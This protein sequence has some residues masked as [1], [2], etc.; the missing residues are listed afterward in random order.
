MQ[1]TWIFRVS[2]NYTGHRCAFVTLEAGRFSHIL[3]Q[4]SVAEA[5]YA[6]DPMAKMTAV[7]TGRILQKVSMHAM[8]QMFP[9]STL[10]QAPAG[11]CIN[12]QRRGRHQSEVDF[13]CDERNVECKSSRLLWDSRTHRWLAC[14][15]RIKFH[16]G[17]SMIHDVLLALHTP[18]RID[19]L[20]HDHVF[21]ISTRG[22]RTSSQGHCVRVRASPGCNPA[23]ARNAIIGRMS[24]QPASCMKVAAWETHDSLISGLIQEE[25][26]STSHELS[27]HCYRNAPLAGKSASARGL[28][29]QRLAFE[30]DR[31]LNPLCI[32]TY[33]VGAQELVGVHQLQRRGSRGSADWLRNR[34]RVEFKNSK[35]H[36]NV[37]AG[38]W[39]VHFFGIKRGLRGTHAAF[40]E[41]W[42]GVYSPF[43]LHLFKHSDELKLTTHG[44]RTATDGHGLCIVAKRHEQDIEVALQVVLSKLERAGCQPLA[45]IFW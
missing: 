31:I 40:D 24:E 16:A 44:V 3:E 10:S 35:L 19:V 43:G 2:G 38:C 23:Q 1:R 15:R 11:I 18:G 4:D 33:G 28:C 34:I 9:Q 45:A 21:G 25:S 7:Q 13:C 29:L 12:G 37:G 41:L 36:W 14:W 30:V 20:L 32:F 22:V 6:E 5:A 39:M 26:R 42:L 27:K 8:A 17:T